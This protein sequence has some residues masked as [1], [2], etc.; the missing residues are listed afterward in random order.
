MAKEKDPWVAFLEAW[1]GSDS[2]AEVAEKLGVTKT[3][4]QGKA[5]R[6]RK[7]GVPLKRFAR[8]FGGAV[9]DLDTLQKALAKMRGTS[10]ANIKKTAK[11]EQVEIAKRAKVMQDRL[12]GGGKRRGR[13]KKKSSK[14]ARS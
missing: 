12:A 4:V 1:E 9:I 13:P 5:S 6:L 10:V 2:T 14:K 3:T 7:A 11:E 8:G